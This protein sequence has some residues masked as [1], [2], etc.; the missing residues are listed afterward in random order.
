MAI[1]IIEQEE[2]DAGTTVTFLDEAT[3]DRLEV[4]VMSEAQSPHH[5]RHAYVRAIH[6]GISHQ[7]LMSVLP[8]S[9]NTVRV[10]Y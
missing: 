6:N 3:G 1:K 8:V 4:I 5:H 7:D 10:R 2:T 9:Q